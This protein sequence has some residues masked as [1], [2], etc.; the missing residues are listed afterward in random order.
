M[1]DVTTER[2]RPHTRFARN[3]RAF[4]DSIANHDV[5]LE[6]ERAERGDALGA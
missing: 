6:P 4:H 2:T 5:I 1:F 3:V